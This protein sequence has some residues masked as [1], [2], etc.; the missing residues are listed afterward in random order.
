MKNGQEEQDLAEKDSK[1]SRTTNLVK[2]ILSTKLDEIM[3]I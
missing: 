2:K 1:S 3:R